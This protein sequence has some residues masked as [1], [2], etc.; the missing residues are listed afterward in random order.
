MICLIGRPLSGKTTVSERLAKARNWNAFHPGVLVRLLKPD[1]E[2]INKWGWSQKWNDVIIAAAD[3]MP[4]NTV[5]DGYPRNETQWRIDA[6]IYCLDMPSGVLY[7]RAEN[8]R[9][10]DDKREIIYKRIRAFDDFLADLQQYKHV[11]RFTNADELYVAALGEMDAQ[12]AG[13]VDR[14]DPELPT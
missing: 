11:R 1:Q 7:R 14:V 5:L 13:Q 8:R 12:I 2:F 3:A 4:W 10:E 6:P 9:R